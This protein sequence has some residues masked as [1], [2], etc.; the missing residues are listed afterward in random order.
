MDGWYFPSGIVSPRGAGAEI[1]AWKAGDSMARGGFE[2]VSVGEGRADEVL[3]M[4]DGEDAV[5]E[6]RPWAKKEGFL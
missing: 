5:E 3:D 1:A 2:V 6:G 4:P